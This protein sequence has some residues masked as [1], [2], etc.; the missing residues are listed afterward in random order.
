MD[1]ALD[2]GELCSASKMK[3]Y[4]EHI[5]LSTARR[6]VMSCRGEGSA[7]RV[8]DGPADDSTHEG[9]CLRAQVSEPACTPAHACQLSAMLL[10]LLR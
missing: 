1:V 8:F 2:H 5:V 7:H 9:I 6:I 10:A 3:H 4:W